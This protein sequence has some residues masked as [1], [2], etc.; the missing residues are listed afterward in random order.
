MPRMTAAQTVAHFL[1][2]A[3][4][5]RYY[6]YN[7]HANW[8]LLD[9]LEYEAR[10]PGIRMRHEIHAIHAADVEWRMRRELPIP[11]TC[12]TVGPGNFNTIP[13]IAEAFYD[14]TP[15]LCLMAGGP[16]KWYG[17]GGIQEVYRYGDDE[18]TQLFKNI[19]KG[20]FTTY[21]PDTALRTVM[22]AYKT[23]ITGR[24]GPVVVYMPLD[25]QNTEVEVDLPTRKELAD[26][27]LPHPPAPDPDAV[28]A[29]VALLAKARRPLIYTSS[30]VL[31]AH[32]W[33]DLRA[34]AEAAQIPVATT[35]GGKGGIPEDHP[36]SL[37]VCDRSGTGHAVKAAQEAD[38]VLGIGVRFNDL[39]TAGWTIFDI[40]RKTTLVH[41]DIDPGEIGRVYPAR[42]G[43][44][45]DAK[46]ALKALQAAWQQG[47]HEPRR[48]AWLRQIAG[49]RKAW[50]AEVRAAV[51]SDAEPLHYARIVKDTSDAVNAFD[52]QAS[53]VCDTGFIMNYV[54]AFYT[55]KS[56]W[57]A[58]NN[59]Q[60]GQMGFA[61]PGVVGAGMER[62]RHPVV[63][64]VGDQSF[65][66]T[67]LAL[68]TATEYGVPGVV[69]VLNNKTIQAEVEGAQAKFGRG[70]GD[71]YR[72]EKTG[73]P[74]NPDIS[75]IAA[76][77]RARVF[78]VERAADFKPAVEAAL[79]SGQ[80]CVIDVECSSTIKR[81]AVPVVL[82][83][84]TMPFPYSWNQDR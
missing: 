63:V 21:R 68:A 78:R 47:G 28:A 15:M 81:Y 27:L 25:V 6:L 10:I 41:V 40:P 22:R 9:A 39:N 48:A 36:L 82:Q 29:A 34:F 84:G 11:V 57:F 51:T 4:T 79:A 2:R 20:A 73:E 16:T 69:I 46:R 17:R 38:L 23:A 5:K 31:N 49:W 70:V 8:G 42:I 64:F 77:M 58:T 60:F 18:F 45:A 19:T 71:H 3:G 66:H 43:M 75:Q 67:G 1:R 54:P 55:L 83:H 76:A 80:L 65:V 13:G 50:T 30:G 14:S 7:G 44:V 24:P 37:G 32:A 62:R 26:W 72:I 53:L 12:T 59:Q 33:D 74:W 52:P 56:P 35:F 61:P